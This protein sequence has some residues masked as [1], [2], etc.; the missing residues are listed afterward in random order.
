[1]GW[2]RLS[3][4]YLRG[5]YLRDRPPLTRISL[6][7]TPPIARTHN[8][9]ACPETAE[10]DAQQRI[11]VGDRADRGAGVGAQMLLVDYDR[12]RQAIQHVDLRPRQ[13]RKEALHEGAVGLV[14]HPL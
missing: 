12:C 10:E 8:E 7:V 11:G 2:M 3:G 13:R 1:M 5:S 14:D 4:P 9:Q 6:I